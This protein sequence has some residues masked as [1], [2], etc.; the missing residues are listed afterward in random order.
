[1][2]QPEGGGR[3]RRRRQAQGS[4]KDDDEGGG[5]A[6]EAGRR[7]RDAVAEA[8]AAGAVE[9]V[10]ARQQAPA[11]AGAAVQRPELDP[12]PHAAAR[13]QSLVLTHTRHSTANIGSDPSTYMLSCLYYCT[14]YWYGTSKLQSI[15][16]HDRSTILHTILKD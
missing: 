12:E 15:Y 11:A 13:R 16:T 5:G 3:S 2:G 4:D 6:R 8:L 14:W 1:M 9:E 7:R 10:D